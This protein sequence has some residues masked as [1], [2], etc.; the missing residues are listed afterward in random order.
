MK[1]IKGLVGVIAMALCACAQ[2]TQ[3]ADSEWSSESKRV[4]EDAVAV[5]IN[6]MRSSA[7]R[8]RLERVEPSE[9]EVELVCTAA[10]TGRRV[11]DPQMGGLATYATDDLL[12]ETETLKEMTVGRFYPT[13]VW[14]RYSVIV[15][16]NANKTPDGRAFTIG[17]ARRKSAIQEFFAPIFGDVPFKDMNDWKSKVAPECKKRKTSG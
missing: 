7:T 11:G 17:I 9:R 15:E 12:A 2:T 13:K 16:R 10:L 4:A 5:K 14:P 1:P 8:P 6:Q 3:Q